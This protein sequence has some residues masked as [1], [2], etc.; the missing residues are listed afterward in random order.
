[1]KKIIAI[2]ILTIVLIAVLIALLDSS[3]ITFPYGNFTQKL[4]IGLE[5]FN[6][7]LMFLMFVVCNYVYA[8]TKDERLIIMAGGF[9][10][11]SIFNCIHIA[12]V[13]TF[14]FD[15]MSIANLHK[16]PGLVYLLLSN[17]II[18]I[19]IYFA[20]VHKP[21]PQEIPNFRLKVYN[22]YF[23]IFLILTASPFF[24][25]YYLPELVYRF[26]MIIHALE[27]IN[28]SLYFMLAFMIINIRQASNLTI[29]PIFTTGLT[30]SGLAG[31]F[32]INPNLT[33]TSEIL[34]HIFQAVG[35]LFLIFGVSHF[36]M[37]AKF[38]RF[39]DELVAYLCL[40][41]ISFYVIFISL[42]SA[43]F[44]IVF[45]SFSSYLFIEILLI[46]QLIIYLFANEITK[47]IT[48]ITEALSK[49]IPGKEPVNIPISRQDEI[50]ML[51]EKINATSALS[52]QKISEI[53][54]ILEREHALIRIFETMRRIT[55]QIIIKNT[56]IDEIKNLFHADKCFIAL[57][58]PSNNSFYFDRYSE[59]LPSKTL[60]NYEDIS[61]DAL[62]FEQ[63]RDVF[64]NNIEI[65]FA[66]IEDYI[67]NNSLQHTKQEELLKQ[68][69]IKSLY[70]FPIY[71][72]NNLFGYVILQYTNEYTKLDKEEL[73]FLK[74]LAT[75]IGI[76]I[77]QANK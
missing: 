25:H 73:S 16:K 3:F 9:L 4:H 63:F 6:S 20:I 70:S 31:L 30:I 5:G 36:R 28:Y 35:L 68:Y 72:S 41:L 77:H 2:Y 62:K 8:K 38:L 17:L 1:M 61:D 43:I 12:T 76:V 23:L 65:N 48:N 64:K 21:S 22:I 60:I 47:P 44:H 18:P 40:G 58:N 14:P 33:P 10:I 57:F 74:T 59:N 53:A 45:P 27:F 26:N 75:Q 34:A 15:F 69:N 24:I 39:K 29:L 67:I 51:T 13:N 56:I 66:N 7:L 71:Y 37:Y 50:G 46:F 32:Y 55:D 19:S 11:G 54:Q 49:Y 42:T 52:W